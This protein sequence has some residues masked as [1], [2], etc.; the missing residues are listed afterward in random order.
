LSSRLSAVF[1]CVWL[2]HVNCTAQETTGTHCFML[3]FY[4]VY[5][6]QVCFVVTNLPRCCNITI[7]QTL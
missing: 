2:Y 3:N 5:N 7:L 6:K 1:P 4:T